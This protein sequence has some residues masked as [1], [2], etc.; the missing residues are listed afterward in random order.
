MLMWHRRLWL[1]DHGASL[2]FHHQAGW[3]SGGSRAGDPFP[4]IK[5]HVLARTATLLEE[6]DAPMAG[7]LTPTAIDA[8]VDMVPDAWLEEAAGGGEGWRTRDAYRRH[9]VDRVT[10]PRAFVAEAMR[11]N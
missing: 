8:I 10:A 5:D 9:L 3:E 2:Y 11:A 6:I 7:A 4:M 1:I